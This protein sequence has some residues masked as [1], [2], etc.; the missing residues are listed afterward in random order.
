MRIE[1]SGKH[2]DV[3]EAI[4]TYAEGKCA[5]LPRFFDGVMEIKV[6]LST[7]EKGHFDA[8]LVVDAVR[9]EPFVARS[10]GPHLYACI[11]TVVDK[12]SRQLHDFKEILQSNKR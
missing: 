3:T 12:M 7:A 10:T 11:D 1:V 8:E 5:R 6:V 2:L 9:H 4:R